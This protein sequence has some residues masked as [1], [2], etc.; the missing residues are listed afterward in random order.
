MP[1][2][3]GFLQIGT[4][5][6]YSMAGLLGQ[7]DFKC[8]IITPV[9]RLGVLGFLSSEEL[10]QEAALDGE[11]SGN[12][13]LWD[14]RLALEWTSRIAHLF[15]GNPL[16]ITVSGFSAGISHHILLPYIKA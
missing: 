13:G 11:S 15:N 9:Y 4:P 1:A 14:Q 5:N 6:S 8:I 16:K 10:Q 12:Q 3:G 2:D 7:T